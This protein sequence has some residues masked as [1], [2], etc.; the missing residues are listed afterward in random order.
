MVSRRLR[1]YS[2]GGSGGRTHTVLADYRI[3]S[4]VRLPITPSR[5]YAR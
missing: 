3:L 4:P 5:R 2:G 1:S